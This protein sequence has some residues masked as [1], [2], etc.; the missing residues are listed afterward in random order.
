MKYPSDQHGVN[1]IETLYRGYRFRSRLEARWAVMFDALGIDWSYEPQGY[2][3]PFGMY[4][5]DFF[6]DVGNRHRGPWIEIKGSAPTNK[7]IQ[8]LC[9]VCAQTGA[10]GRLVWGIPRYVDEMD[11]AVSFWDFPTTTDT[12][13]HERNEDV[14]LSAQW[15]SIDKE[16]FADGSELIETLAHDIWPCHAVY[17]VFGYGNT[18]ALV[19]CWDDAVTCARAARFEHGESPELPAWIQAIDPCRSGLGPF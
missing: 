11:S 1:A 15:V 9:A 13:Q 2:Y 18:K 19:Q 3:T 14:R 7:E 8:K 17:D 6:L 16:G 10:Y 12:A 4:L 5:P